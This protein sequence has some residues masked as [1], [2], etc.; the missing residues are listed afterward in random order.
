MHIKAIADRYG[1]FEPDDL[2][3]LRN[4][5]DEIVASKLSVHWD[6]GEVAG[7]LLYLFDSG[8]RDRELLY[9]AAIRPKRRTNT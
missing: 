4:I 9:Q 6:E 1:I 8:I 2:A 7:K 3:L 5:Y